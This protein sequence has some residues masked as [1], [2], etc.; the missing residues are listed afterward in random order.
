[1]R[2]KNDTSHTSPPLRNDDDDRRYAAQTCSICFQIVIQIQPRNV[3]LCVG[4]FP[5]GFYFGI[6]NAGRLPNCWRTLRELIGW[7]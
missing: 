3:E 7:I 1:M 4:E 5:G 6:F 2:S